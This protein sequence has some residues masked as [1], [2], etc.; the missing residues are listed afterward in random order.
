M[1]AEL[2]DLFREQPG[3]LHQMVTMV[4]PHRLKS[5]HG[6]PVCRAVQRPGNYIITFPRAYHGGFNAGLNCAEAVNFAPADWLPW[7]D[8]AV[9]QY[10]KEGKSPT[11]AQVC[12]TVCPQLF[13]LN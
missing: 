7:G 3:L 5:N 2:P 6:V 1:K 12:S 9:A 4:A 13:A 11:H 10:V 8:K